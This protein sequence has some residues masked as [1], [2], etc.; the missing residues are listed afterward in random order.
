MFKPAR[1]PA[2]ER[3]AIAQAVQRLYLAAAEHAPIAADRGG[4]FAD[5]SAD[6]RMDCVDHSQNDTTFLQYL[7][8][9]GLLQ[10][11]RVA[12][13]VWR[14]P[15]IIDLHY[16]SQIIEIASETPWVVDSWFFDFGHEPVVVPYQQWKK[17]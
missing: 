15:W 2:E 4:N 1:Q 5:G 14:A 6:G 13:P 17:G 16:A 11:H 7:A 12:A 10:H 9:Q 3:A 8:Q